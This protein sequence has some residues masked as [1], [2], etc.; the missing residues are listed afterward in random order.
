MNLRGHESGGRWIRF[1]FYQ[2]RPTGVKTEVSDYQWYDTIPANV[3]LKG[4]ALAHVPD[5]AQHSERGFKYGFEVMRDGLSKE[6]SQTLSAKYQAIIR[7][8]T[9]MLL[10]LVGTPILK[11][12]KKK[13]ERKKK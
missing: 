10:N 5:W 3:T 8:A 9:C 13:S 6:A 7:G 4:E 11:T 12:K 2:K 1:W